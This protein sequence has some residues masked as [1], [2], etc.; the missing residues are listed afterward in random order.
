VILAIAAARRGRVAEDLDLD[1]SVRSTDL[2]IRLRDWG[3]CAAPDPAT[4]RCR[5]DLDGN[6]AVDP[7]D[8]SRLLAAWTG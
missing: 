5:S 6:G 3:P 8:L 7:A 4:G 1:G 2:A